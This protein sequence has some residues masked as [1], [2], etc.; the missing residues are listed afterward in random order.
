MEQHIHIPSDRTP[1]YLD[2]SVITYTYIYL[3]SIQNS[4]WTISLHN[5]RFLY[6]EYSIWHRLLCHISRNSYHPTFNSRSTRNTHLDTPR[7][8]TLCP[9]NYTNNHNRNWNSK[10]QYIPLLSEGHHINKVYR[11]ILLRNIE[12]IT[13]QQLLLIQT[14]NNIYYTSQTNCNNHNNQSTDHNK[15]TSHIVKI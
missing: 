10:L 15:N 9:T 13:I 14:I 8:R 6:I 3:R 1:Q 5:L 12:T 7:I 11:Y 2:H 4:S